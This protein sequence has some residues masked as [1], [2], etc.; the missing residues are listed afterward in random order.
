MTWGWVNYK[1]ILIWKWTNPL[2]LFIRSITGFFFF[3]FFFYSYKKQVKAGHPRSRFIC[4]FIRTDLEKCSITLLAH[5]WI[6]CSEWVPSELE[7]KQLIKT[8]VMWFTVPVPP[9]HWFPPTWGAFLGSILPCLGE[10]TSWPL[11]LWMVI[12]NKKMLSKPDLCWNIIWTFT[13]L[14]FTF[15]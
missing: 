14:I 4:V 12:W 7:S 9:A 3:A 5:Q 10:L 11:S 13:L 8:W 6:F 2:T 15:C 1:E